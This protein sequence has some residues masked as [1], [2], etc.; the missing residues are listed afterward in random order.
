[1]KNKR[2]RFSVC[3]CFLTLVLGIVFY[4]IN[5][6][7]WIVFGVFRL[8]LAESVICYVTIFFIGLCVHLLMH[9]GKNGKKHVLMTSFLPIFFYFSFCREL[10]PWLYFVWF[11]LGLFLLC[12]DL[13]GLPKL[14][15]KKRTIACSHLIEKRLLQTV[16]YIGIFS[17]VS[18]IAGEMYHSSKTSSKYE[19]TIDMHGAD[20]DAQY[21]TEMPVLASTTIGNLWE[22]NKDLLVELN[23]NRYGDKTLE[24]RLNAW[25]VFLAV[26]CAYLGCSRVPLLGT[27]EI[28]RK[29]C[30]AYYDPQSE[31]IIIDKK[32]LLAG[33]RRVEVIRILLHEVYH[34]YSNLASQEL[35]RMQNAGVDMHLMFARQIQEWSFEQTHYISYNPDTDGDEDYKLYRQQ[36]L[37]TAANDYMGEWWFYWLEFID[38]I[39]PIEEEYP[40]E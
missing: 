13:Q 19:Q 20:P 32:Y 26:D 36:S 23:A 17:M 8:T 3:S 37:E 6:P 11:A 12:M 5:L 24:E 18:F 40:K 2:I 7:K 38:T 4:L 29:G 15:K 39:E 16:T 14:S 21:A 22:G 1:M 25:E 28:S 33:H 31:T 27:K 34:H 10:K 35:S 30:H 9:K